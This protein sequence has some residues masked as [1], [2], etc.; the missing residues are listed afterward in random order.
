MDAREMRRDEMTFKVSLVLENHYY[1]RIVAS[2]L[3]ALQ[4]PLGTF[5][6]IMAS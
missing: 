5:V 3:K 4:R 2:N 6:P 1:R